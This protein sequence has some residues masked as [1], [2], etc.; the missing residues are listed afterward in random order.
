MTLTALSALQEIWQFSI[1]RRTLEEIRSCQR[2]EHRPRVQAPHGQRRTHEHTCINGCHAVPGVS[3]NRRKLCS[4]GERRKGD[5]SQG[6]FRCWRSLEIS[7]NGAFWEKKS[8]GLS[9]M[10]G[11]VQR[12]WSRDPWWYARRWILPLDH[13]KDVL[14]LLNR[15]KSK[16]LYNG[17]RL[18][19]VQ[20]RTWYTRLRWPLDGPIYHGRLHQGKGHGTWCCAAHSPVCQF[21][22]SIW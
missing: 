17:G 18:Q 7:S 15:P 3:A 2:L 6:P 20:A 11:S 19:Q 21:H 8:K 4:T 13:W 16:Q 22:G 1:R 5:C 12:K 10:G 9:R 14:T